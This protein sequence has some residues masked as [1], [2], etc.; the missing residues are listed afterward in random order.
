[1]AEDGPPPPS[2]SQSAMNSPLPASSEG[3]KELPSQPPTRTSTPSQ[4]S[5]LSTS[6]QLQGSKTNETSAAGSASPG[7][8]V[9]AT[10]D[11]PA[12]SA[13]VPGPYGTRS[14]NRGGAPR[15]NYAEDVEMDFEIPRASPAGSAS[16]KAGPAPPV[17]GE[18]D[19]LAASTSKRAQANYEQSVTV[20][21]T[22]SNSTKDS[23]PGMST[24]SAN[25]HAL[26]Q[27]AVVPKKRKAA[28][29][30]QAGTASSFGPSAV[31]SSTKKSASTSTTSTYTSG[32][33]YY[34]STNIMSFE[35]SK[36]RLKDGKLVADDGTVL[37]VDG[38][39]KLFDPARHF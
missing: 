10:P 31:S 6:E 34:R 15:I 35:K 25:P 3:A 16:K 7:P 13:A 19:R 21:G 20:N 14:R 18:K 33:M 2:A 28:G 32:T 37:G 4:R 23:I 38:T 26:P 17:A 5:R 22:P 12:G 27:P 9:A 11:D 30:A 29:S 8:S 36:G 1:M 24:F 39:Y